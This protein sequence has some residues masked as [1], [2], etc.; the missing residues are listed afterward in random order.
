VNNGQ[1]LG[2]L[3]YRLADIR[4]RPEI[5]MRI[6][7]FL[8]CEKAAPWLAAETCRIATRHEAA[9]ADFYC[10]GPRFARA[11][12]GVGFVREEEQPIHLPA[13]FQPLDFRSSVLNC[14]FKVSPQV[15]ADSR[16]Y[17]QREDVYFTR[18]DS[19]QDRP[20]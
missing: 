16:D 20:N 1:L 14:A 11:L 9:F 8:A 17:F 6:V 3:V 12:E 7:E 5:V 10:T 2:I 19:D 13:L 18:S 4:D 15:A